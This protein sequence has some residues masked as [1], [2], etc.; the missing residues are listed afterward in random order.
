[1][2]VFNTPDIILE[3]TKHARFESIV[4]LYQLNRFCQNIVAR[5]ISV[6]SSRFQLGYCITL[7]GMVTRYKKKYPDKHIRIYN[8]VISGDKEY[9]EVQNRYLT[10]NKVDK[11]YIS[12]LRGLAFINDVDD[13]LI[14]LNSLNDKKRNRILP[15]IFKSAITSS[16]KEVVSEI[17][18]YCYQIT[19]DLFQKII[20]E[21]I[22]VAIENCSSEFIQWLI[23]ELNLSLVI[24]KSHILAV[25]RNPYYDVID[26]I[27]QNIDI[28][29]SL[30]YSEVCQEIITTGKGDIRY[31]INSGYLTIEPLNVITLCNLMEM[32][33]MHF[34]LDP[35]YRMATWLIENHDIGWETGTQLEPYYM[36]NWIYSDPTS[37]MLVGRW[38]IAADICR[39]V[40]T[41][42]EHMKN[43]NL[44]FDKNKLARIGLYSWRSE[45]VEWSQ[46]YVKLEKRKKKNILDKLVNPE[47]VIY[48]IDKKEMIR[49]LT[50]SIT[51]DNLELA[52]TKYRVYN[53]LVK[54]TKTEVLKKYKKKKNR[55]DPDVLIWYREIA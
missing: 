1:M 32:C 50:I 31:L 28:S 24:D 45:L 43:D 44:K 46:E 19:S 3:I 34:Y 38:E 26:W 15:D 41:K 25:I 47:Y 7:N 54:I 42:N 11:L 36:Y 8:A 53:N 6:L 55:F 27:G 21:I 2:Q 16:S 20:D 13:L 12:Y 23:E 17:L 5:Q 4:T 35:E 39:T 22:I 18:Y 10:N 40:L 51:E 33:I 14:R 29:H 30:E 37:G 9:T 49:A 48:R 52:I